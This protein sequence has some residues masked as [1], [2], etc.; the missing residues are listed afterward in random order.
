MFINVIEEMDVVGK[1]TSDPDWILLKLDMVG[2]NG[3]N[4]DWNT[5]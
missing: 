3:S 4:P 5:I 1:N 2:K